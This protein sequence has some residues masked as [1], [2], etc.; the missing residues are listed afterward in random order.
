MS[1]NVIQ[2]GRL[3][4]VAGGGGSAPAESPVVFLNRDVF[5]SPGAADKIYLALD[6]DTLYRYDVA[7]A[8]YIPLTGT[9][10]SGYATTTQLEEVRSEVREVPN[11]LPL[12]T[13]SDIDNLF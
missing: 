8:T 7:A 5:P 6:E 13:T 4:K 1:V 3:I 11:N 10:M 2:N 12:A 9:D